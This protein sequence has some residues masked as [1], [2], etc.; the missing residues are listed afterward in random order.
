M[1][2]ENSA[3]CMGAAPRWTGPFAWDEGDVQIGPG[4]YQIPLWVT[5]PKKV[6]KTPSWPRSWANSSLL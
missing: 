6:R 3:D 5:L 1:A 2:C 4:V